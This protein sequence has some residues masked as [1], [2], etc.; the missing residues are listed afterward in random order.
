MAGVLLGLAALCRP[1][2]WAYVV[3]SLAAALWLRLNTRDRRFAGPSREIVVLAV[4]TLLVVSPWMIR[5]A[6]VFGRPIVTTT[7]G[8]YTLLLGN[9]ESFYRDV[10]TQPFGATWP[11]DK[12]AAW[13]QTIEV[14][15]DRQGVP[16]TD[17]VARDAAMKSL[18]IEWM[19]ANP[20]ATLSCVWFRI[21]N[22]WSPVPLERDGIPNF[23]VWVVGAY[24]TTVLL[25][26]VVGLTRQRLHPRGQAASQALL[27]SLTLLHALYWANTRMRA[28]AVPV[29]AI[30]AVA[31]I[32][33][34]SRI[35]P[36][37][38][39]SPTSP[40]EQLSFDKHRPST[41]F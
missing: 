10:V 14:E 2:I 18:A 20:A 29:L 11:A 5:N 4:T 38:P 16:R 31:G 28:P 40:S 15:I 32:G 27:L 25:S 19:R 21:R 26:V 9:N 34:L 24:Y 23:V 8:G 12:L 39:D 35:S 33:R 3:L 30:L 36:I 41:K 22:L 1:T 17:E 13:Q 7:H 37:E 6:I